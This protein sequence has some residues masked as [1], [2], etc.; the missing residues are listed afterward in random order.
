MATSVMTTEE[1]LKLCG[2]PTDTLLIQDAQI[3]L[4]DRLV[5]PV[6]VNLTVIPKT[7]RIVRTAKDTKHE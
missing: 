7:R 3:E 6:K 2:I 5:E 4:G 1:L